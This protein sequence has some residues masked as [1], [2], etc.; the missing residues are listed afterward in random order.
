MIPPGQY[1]EN[2]ALAALALRNDHLRNAAI[3]ECGTWKGGMAAGL[4]EVGGP[5]RR[6]IFF[7]SFE[8][9]PPAQEIDGQRAIQWQANTESPLYYD[10][11]SASLEEFKDTISKAGPLSNVEIH[12]GFFEET[13]KDFTPPPIGILRLDADWYASTML[14]LRKFWDS[15]LNCGVILIDDYYNWDGCARAVHEFLAK[16]DSCDRVQQGPIGRVAYIVKQY[17]GAT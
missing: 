3:V 12:K 8:G 11:C 16:Q 17:H 4:M 15:V 1:V 2:L 9:L 14:C 6:Y 7:D 5:S 13:F 10:N